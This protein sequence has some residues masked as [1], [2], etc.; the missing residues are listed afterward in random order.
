MLI[1]T[2]CFTEFFSKTVCQFFL[3]NE[4]GEVLRFTVQ[5]F[6]C[7][8]LYLAIEICISHTQQIRQL[9]WSTGYVALLMS[10][11]PGSE[12]RAKIEIGCLHKL[13]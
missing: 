4:N 6:P 1:D 7:I 9:S 8:T 3:V 10:R 13:R 5:L 2:Y 11:I 12:S